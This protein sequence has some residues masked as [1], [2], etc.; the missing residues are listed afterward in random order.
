[1][2]YLT[3]GAKNVT[4]IYFLYFSK[5]LTSP[6]VKE[7]RRGNREMVLDAENEEH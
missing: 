7:E 4:Y 2:V 1:M 5:F 6:S 3:F